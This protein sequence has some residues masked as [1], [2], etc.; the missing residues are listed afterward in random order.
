MTAHLSVRKKRLAEAAKANRH[1]HR[2]A[3]MILI[4]YDVGENP[5]RDELVTA[6]IKP[7]NGTLRIPE[8]P[9]LGIELRP[10][11]LERYR[12]A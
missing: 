8:G 10:D 2:D 7:S 3:T 4:E 5:L 6:T 11:T 1:G 9:G 12:V